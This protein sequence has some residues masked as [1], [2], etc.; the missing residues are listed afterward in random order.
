MNLYISIWWCIA[1]FTESFLFVCLKWN[2]RY[3]RN[4]GDLLRVSVF[5]TVKIQ[6]GSRDE[7]RDNQDSSN[8]L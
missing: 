3:S 1:T 7:T 5:V 8:G 6:L 2:L 4:S